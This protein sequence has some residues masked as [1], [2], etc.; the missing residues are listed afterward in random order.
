MYMNICIYQYMYTY[1]KNT[2]F[3]QYFLKIYIFTPFGGSSGHPCAPPRAKE[4][5]LAGGASAPGGTKRM[6]E[7]AEGRRLVPSIY[8]LA[9]AKHSPPGSM[10]KRRAKHFR[11]FRPPGRPN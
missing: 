5:A 11:L 6:E 1:E 7:L 4:P 9:H 8:W 2:Y 10:Y 3:F